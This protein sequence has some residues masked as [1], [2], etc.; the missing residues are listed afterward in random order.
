[1][2]TATAGQ[3]PGGV[4]SS[5]ILSG[6]PD[7]HPTAV[8]FISFLCFNRIVLK[9]Y[10]NTYFNAYSSH[11]SVCHLSS[12]CHYCE[13]VS[14]LNM[15]TFFFFFLNL[16]VIRTLSGP[17]PCQMYKPSTPGLDFQREMRG[18]LFIPSA[19]HF[20]GLSF[21]GVFIVT[22]WED[23]ARK[24]PKQNKTKLHINRVQ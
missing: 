15:R 22:L 5:R 1:M 18:F 6:I 2:L 4:S 10:H 16:G 24:K 17:T 21:S 11:L 12:I 13:H 9:F 19:F 14:L 8:K 7:L 20:L 3:K 23:R